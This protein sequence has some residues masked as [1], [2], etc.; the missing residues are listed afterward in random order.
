MGITHVD[1]I[2][3]ELSSARFL[4]IDRVKQ[5][6]LPDFDLDLESRTPLVGLDGNSGY[7][8]NKYQNKAAQISTRSLLRIKSAILDANR[9]INNGEVE[10]EITKFSKSLPNTPQG[11][12]DNDFV[13]GYEDEDG[14]HVQGLLEINEDL[15][16][17]AV[18]RPKEWDIVKRALSLSRQYSRHACSFVI[19]N[20]CI[21]DVVPT[22]EVGGVKRITQPEAKQCE[23]AGLIKYDFLV[24][25][26]LKDI[27][28]CIKYI[29]KK[30]NNLSITTGYFKHDDKEIF[31]WDLP[32]D[33]KVFKML[34]DGKTE[35]VFQLN[36]TSVTPFV[37]K[38][39]PQSVLD[40]ATITAL[41]R[42]GPLDFKD[43][44]TGRNMAEEYIYRRHGVS[45][46]DLP[47]LDK[48]LPETYGIIIFQEEVSKIAKE[49]GQMSVE[50]AE[51][52]RIGMGKKKI[53]LLNSLKPKFIEGASKIT[54]KETAEKVWSMMATFA[55]YGFSKN[56]AVA[57]SVIS[58][59][60]AYLKYY[61]PLE[62]WAAV[63]S[64]ASDKEIN[65]VFYKYVK[66]II[67]P[68][69]INTS[70]EQMEVDYSL[71]KIRNKLSMITGIGVSAAEKLIKGRPYKDIKDF[72][73]KNVCGPTMTKKL[74]H[75]GVLDSLFNKE[76]D[77]IQKMDE[78]EKTV[79][80][81]EFEKKIKEYDKKL[82]NIKDDEKGY[83]R[84]LNN[85]N[86]YIEKDLPSYQIDGQYIGLTPKQDFLM[87]KAIFPTMNL[88]LQAVLE[89]NSNK[90]IMD[91]SK[92][93]AIL[94]PTGKEVRLVSGETLQ[95]VDNTLTTSNAYFCAPGYVMEANEFSY[96][97]GARKAL[98]LIID[99]SGYISEKV[100]WPD[101][102]TGELN[103][104]KSL[105]KGCIAYFCYSKKEG[106]V[107]TNIWHVFIEE[108]SIL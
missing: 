5:G 31:I 87:K 79:K 103:Y 14:S 89:K 95:S 83:Q 67:L 101:Y 29:N 15:Q 96:Q 107:Y 99:S 20:T 55:R 92:Y 47:I 106:K 37:K 41:V 90:L 4:T 100:L 59:A 60:C 97:G 56:H 76:Y 51:N 13:F 18:N 2:K 86:K 70:T 21:E 8:F 80:L 38:I 65:E 49:L 40:C 45:K 25:S 82:E 98:K 73:E 11:I 88:N 16:K 30:H 6:N 32:E 84:A 71:N 105:K 61:Y 74:I 64:N 3:Y 35:S 1:P 28:L 102:E 81:I 85:K 12:S 50:D 46:G 48:L 63:L 9:F 26:A 75:V 22:F 7:L 19:S 57:Y 42:P 53:K 108:K 58:Y 91:N 72:I 62:W 10:E 17:Y 66:D 23:F 24:V 68:P 54:D 39:R 27:N 43:E 78:Y 94:G 44:K 93:K 36:T 77:L 34:S 33:P 104:P 69:D 52:V